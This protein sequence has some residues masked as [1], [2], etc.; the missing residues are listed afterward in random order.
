MLRITIVDTPDEEKWIL[1]GRLS[2][3]WAAELQANWQR[4]HGENNGRSCTV[5]LSEV[6][7]VDANGESVLTEMMREGA[8]FV[9]SGL[10]ATQVVEDLGA[11]CKGW[12]GK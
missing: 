5:D 1:Q 9:V 7:F 10:Y 2:G 11:R 4:A 12:N 6:T 3:P 8:H